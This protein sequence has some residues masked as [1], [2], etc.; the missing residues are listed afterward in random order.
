MPGQAEPPARLAVAHQG[1]VQGLRTEL[2]QHATGGLVDADPARGEGIEIDADG[3]LGI[4]PGAQAARV[5]GKDAEA[6]AP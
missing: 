2:E 4:R 5:V 6:L 3:R 1:E